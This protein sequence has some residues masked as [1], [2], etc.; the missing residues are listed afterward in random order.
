MPVLLIRHAHAGTRKD[1]D[2]D[3]LLRPLSERGVRQARR[4][5]A[6][7]DGLGVQ[8]ILTSPF[9][10]CQTRWHPGQGAGLKLEITTCWRRARHRRV[11]PGALTGPDKVAL[12]THGDVIPMSWWRWPTRTVST[13]DPA[14]AKPRLG[15]GAR[16]EW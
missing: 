12:C 7:A 9:T 4:L 3:D 5:V 15:V 14:P 13:W 10:R 6:T 1:W 2:G 11:A 16:D 8:R